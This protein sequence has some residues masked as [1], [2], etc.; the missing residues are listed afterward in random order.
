[1]QNLFK[2]KTPV[3]NFVYIQ[4]HFISAL[5]C[6]DWFTK[7]I[8]VM[9]F[10][11][12]NDS[13]FSNFTSQICTCHEFEVSFSHPYSTFTHGC[14]W[15]SVILHSSSAVILIGALRINPCHVE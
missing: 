4:C 6:L 15:P 9:N 2:I 10:S 7:Q 12:F 14:K 11:T 8:Q 1:M 13:A 5:T 3:G